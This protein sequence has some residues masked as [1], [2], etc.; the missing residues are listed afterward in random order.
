MLISDGS[1]VLKHKL[2]TKVGVKASASV[3]IYY[4]PRMQMQGLQ[5][6]GKSQ[7][8]NY[9]ARVNPRKRYQINDT[10][11]CNK[12]ID[13]CLRVNRR[14]KGNK[15]IIRS[16]TCIIMLGSETKYK[17]TSRDVQDIVPPTRKCALVREFG[18]SEIK[19][20][21]ANDISMGKKALLNL[22]EKHRHLYPIVSQNNQKI[23]QIRIS[24]YTIK[25]YFFELLFIYF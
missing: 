23:K 2:R 4:L 5:I 15:R 16:H 10:G 11:N 13:S 9:K 7:S 25:T 1:A 24:R 3:C 6:A 8:N 12:V 21:K 17:P 19:E 20:S 14:L 18:D 22:D